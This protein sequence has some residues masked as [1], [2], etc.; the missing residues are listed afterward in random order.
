MPPITDA[1]S[2]EEAMAALD[3]VSEEAVVDL[4]DGDKKDTIIDDEEEDDESTNDAEDGD[5]STDQDEDNGEEEASDSEAEGEGGTEESTDDAEN[6][7]NA[8]QA[9]EPA[10]DPPTG[11]DEKA[12]E[13]FKKLPREQQQFLAEHDRRLVADHTRKTQEAAAIRKTLD[14]RL[15]ALKDVISEKEKRIEKWK[16]VNWKEKARE[17]SAEDYNYNWAAYQEE[18]Q[19]FESLKADKKKQEDAD[20]ADHVRTAWEELPKIAPHLAGEKGAKRREE[21]MKAA[22]DEGYTRDDLRWMS[23]K[24]MKV[25]DEAL[26]WRAYQAEKKNP[27]PK[28]VATKTE[29][30]KGKIIKPSSRGNAP[31]GAKGVVSKK[32]SAKPSQH[33]AMA[34]LNAMDDD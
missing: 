6:G 27:K 17:L 10:I 9:K 7:D 30:S 34:L 32:F 8:E 13:V 20:Y 29:K 18:L 1:L 3:D 12:R 11:M 23:A 31:A 19:E 25:L 5:E 24:E 4:V 33:N 16:T 22:L 28:L 15:E 26:Q 14:V 21:I 2:N